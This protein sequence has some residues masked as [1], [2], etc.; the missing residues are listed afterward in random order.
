[1]GRSLKIDRRKFDDACYIFGTEF[2]IRRESHTC[3]VHD[4]EDSNVFELFTASHFTRAPTERSRGDNFP[5][6]LP[7]FA[8]VYLDANSDLA[9]A[10]SIE[11]RSRNAGH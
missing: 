9:C 4:N 5:Y 2:G 11:L 8:K 3:G 10:N 1:M 7:C 6:A